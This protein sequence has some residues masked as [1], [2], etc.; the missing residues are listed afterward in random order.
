MGMRVTILFFANLREKFGT[1]RYEI[2]LMEGEIVRDVLLRLE[3]ES[4]I[5]VTSLGFMTAVN[6]RY[7]MRTEPLKNGDEIA[8]IPPVSGGSGIQSATYE[9]ADTYIELTTSVL[10]A[11]S[12]AKKLPKSAASGAV[13]SF[14]GVV[15]G[16]HADTGAKVD[17]LHYEAYEEMA[18]K[19]LKWIVK[20][21]RAEHELA[22]VRI[23]HRAGRVAVGE[24]AIVVTI[25]AKHRAAAIL[26]LTK[27]MDEVKT[28]VPIWKKEHL[29][30]GETVWGGAA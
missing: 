26:A 5:P 22:F 14:S 29:A 23:I 2:D 11:A 7:V 24:T 12:E 10:D 3:Q 25:A 21:V 30:S 28:I 13:L 19:I 17:Y 4:G 8:L 1:N 27:I 20:Q 16:E 6:M 18:I 15:R 9:D